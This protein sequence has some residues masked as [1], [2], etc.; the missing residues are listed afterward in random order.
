MPDDV[1]LSWQGEAEFVDAW[2]DVRPVESAREGWHQAE[3]GRCPWTTTGLK[4]VCEDAAFLHAKDVHAKFG[5]P[6]PLL[7]Y[8]DGTYKPFEPFPAPIPIRG[9]PVSP[10]REMRH[11]ANVDAGWRP[12]EGVIATVHHIALGDIM[13]SLQLA[14]YELRLQIREKR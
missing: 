10:P 9:E 12:A 11:P 6:A 4:S 14:G 8:K 2:I 1:G 3:C 7:E 13:A 5:S